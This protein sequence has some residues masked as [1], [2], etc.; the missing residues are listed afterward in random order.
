VDHLEHESL[1]SSRRR[2]PMQVYLT[3]CTVNPDDLVPF[4]AG[5]QVQSDRERHQ[6][7]TA[8]APH[9]VHPD[10]GGEI[11]RGVVL[12]IVWRRFVT[13][14]IRQRDGQVGEPAPVSPAL[15]VRHR[16]PL[17]EPGTAGRLITILEYEKSHAH[18]GVP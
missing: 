15:P 17:P 3:M 9:R 1:F 10:A 16:Q 18:M 14:G 11:F 2:V 7:T 13:Q 12:C 6:T 4:P 8:A 5:P